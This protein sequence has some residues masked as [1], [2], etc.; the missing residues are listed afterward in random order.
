MAINY[1]G[2]ILAAFASMIVGFLWYSKMIFGKQW[3]RFKGYTKETL[4]K[5]QAGMGKL[6]GLSFVM[7][8]LMAYV[9]AHVMIL[10]NSFYGYGMLQT[11]I[12][13]AIFMWL[14][15]IMPVQATGEIFGAKK[16][17]LFAINTGYQLV[18]QTLYSELAKGYF[19]YLKQSY[20]NQQ[21]SYHWPCLKIF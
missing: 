8:L 19:S 1:L 17:N 11:G 3:A 18:A 9:L 15:F 5:A 16:W 10:S 20:L 13:S 14:G 21:T 12:T 6:Y 4:K 2:V 7:T